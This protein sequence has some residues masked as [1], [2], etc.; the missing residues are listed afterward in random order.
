MQK[1][2]E[3]FKQSGELSEEN[4]DLLL[5]SC[6]P[7]TLPKGQVLLQTN[8]WVNSIY[9]IESGF[10]HY[11]T[12]MQDGTRVTLKVVSPNYFWTMLDE[13]F[14]QKQTLDTCVALTD[15]HYC[16]IKRQDYNQLK[17]INTTIA[18]FMHSITEQ[19]LSNKVKEENDKSKMSVEEKYLDLLE[20]NP[21]MVQVVPVG[22]LASYLGTSRETLHRIRRKLS[23]V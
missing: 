15:V 9:F 19:I 16:E 4:L 1:L 7:K 10:L 22:I 6:A 18:N 3:F 12:N 2:R 21:Q 23:S 14:N 8:D 17:S 20:H 13:F 11:Y 5:S